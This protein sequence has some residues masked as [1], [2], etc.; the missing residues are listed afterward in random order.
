MQVT[1]GRDHTCPLLETGAIRC[2]GDGDD[3]TLGYANNN[4]IGDDELPSAAGDVSV[5]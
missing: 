3:G 2:W 1:T 5:W 4:T